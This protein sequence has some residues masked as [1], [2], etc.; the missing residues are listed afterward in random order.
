MVVEELVLAEDHRI[1]QFNGLKQHRVGILNGRR[2]HH[3]QPGVVGVDSLHALTVERTASRCSSARKPHDD[4]AGCAG[5]VV[6]R[7]GLVN[8]LVETASGE[9]S[10]LHLNDGSHPLDRCPDGESHHG[11][12]ADRSIQNPARKFLSQILCGLEC[13]AE[14]TDVLPINEDPWVLLQSPLLR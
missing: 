8:D 3:H 1:L 10:K 6:E 9:V 4:G 14:H 11:I 2:S 12:L 5:A 7:G 13:T